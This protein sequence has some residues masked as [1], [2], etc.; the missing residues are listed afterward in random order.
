MTDQTTPSPR[1]AAEWL[2]ALLDAP[3]DP[4]LR[5]AF[6]H[7]IAEDLAH[8]GEWAEA[9]TTYRLIGRTAPRYTEYWQQPDGTG[10][11]T[12]TAPLPTVSLGRPIPVSTPHGTASTAPSRRRPVVVAMAVAIAACLVISMVPT[13]WVTETADFATGSAQTSSVTLEDG[14]VVRLSAETAITV[15]FQ[16]DDRRVRLL[17]GQAFFDVAPSPARPFT[18]VSGSVETRVVGTAFDVRLGSSAT[19]VAVRSGTVEVSRPGVRSGDGQSFRERL[20][21][22]DWVRMPMEG[23][24]ERGHADPSEVGAWLDGLII[25]HNRPIGEV[26]HE[27]DRYY[28]G[29]IWILGAAL[30]DRPITGV[31]KTTDPV[32]AAAAVA[33]AQGTSFRELPPFGLLLGG[34]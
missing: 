29:S 13:L 15:D 23:P 20:V 6:D 25:A 1:R 18:V 30:A 3:D 4:E 24:V 19:A 32:S 2:V 8:Q 21:A 33:R 17:R 9:V 10:P 26:L 28:D 31:F 27:I 14:S 5:E 7:W 12:A 16:S 22:G 34:P 11:A